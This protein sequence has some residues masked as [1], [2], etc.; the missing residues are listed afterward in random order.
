MRRVA[1]WYS[2]LRSTVVTAVV[3][4]AMAAWVLSLAWE[5][6]HAMGTAKKLKGTEKISC[7]G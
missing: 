2:R 3:H 7:N 4:M 6:A 1:L 5:L